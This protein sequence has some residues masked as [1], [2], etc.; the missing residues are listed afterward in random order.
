MDKA[1]EVLLIVKS[2]QS[3]FASLVKL[4]KSLHSYEVPEIIVLPVESGYLP[5]LD[6]VREE[7]AT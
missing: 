6:W 1:K 3:K 4:V 5:Y 7:T 2:S